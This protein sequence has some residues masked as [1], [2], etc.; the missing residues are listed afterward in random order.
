MRDCPF[1]RF[2]LPGTLWGSALQPLLRSDGRALPEWTSRI[3]SSHHEVLGSG[4]NWWGAEVHGW[5]ARGIVVPWHDRPFLHNFGAWIYRAFVAFP[6]RLARTCSKPPISK[7]PSS[8]CLKFGLVILDC[9]CSPWSPYLLYLLSRSAC[10]CLRQICFGGNWTPYANSVSVNL[11]RHL[12]SS[13]CGCL[14]SLLPTLP[15]PCQTSL[16]I[17][18]EPRANIG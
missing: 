13:S 18:Q 12:L 6:R 2:A 14:L 11:Q 7:L 16:S 15:L 3:L 8:G 1:H 17:L 9:V 4:V 10:S 5:L